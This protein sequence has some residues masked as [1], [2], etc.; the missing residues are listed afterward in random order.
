MARFD[1][2]PPEHLA[3]STV[4]VNSGPMGRAIRDA[5]I[6][7]S[8]LLLPRILP[9]S[10]LE[11]LLADTN[12][13]QAA[14]PIVMRLELTRLVQ[15]KIEAEALRVAGNTAYD[16]AGS[17]LRLLGEM[18]S[19]GV[20][21][22]DLGRVDVEG[23]SDHWARNLAFVAL[24]DRFLS[25]DDALEPEARQRRV[26]DALIRQ[27]ASSP[28]GAPIFIAGSTGSR[29]TT[30]MLIEAVASEEQGH[31]VLPGF[32]FELPQAQWAKLPEDHPQY[33]YASLM[34]SLD[35]TL[36]D[37]TAWA[38]VPSDPNRQKVLS[39]ALRPPPAT[40]HWVKDGPKLPALQSALANVTLI[41]ADTQQQEAQ[42]IALG[43]R[44]AVEEGWSVAVI[45]PDRTLTRRIGAALDRWSIA[46][47]DSAGRPLALSAPGRLL[48]QIS[49]LTW[50][51][52]PLADMLALLKHPLVGTGGDRGQHL[53]FIREFEIWV[54]RKAVAFCDTSV[55]VRWA[56]D[57]PARQAW[58]AWVT[59]AMPAERSD[60]LFDLG[61][62]LGDLERSA[63]A[64]ARGADGTE[65]GGLWEE[66]AGELAWSQLQ[67]LAQAAWASGPVSDADFA[68]ILTSVLQA[69]V[70]DPVLPHDDVVFRG[71]LEARTLDSDLVILAGLNE[72]TWPPTE[73]HDPWLN[74]S[75]RK[76]AGLLTPDRRTGLS[77][78]DFEQ[79][80]SSAHVWFS[81]TLR[82]DDGETV[83]ARWLNRL[84]NLVGGLPTRGGPDALSDIR[85]RGD[86]W[87]SLA[88]EIDRRRPPEAPAPRPAPAPPVSARPKKLSVTA[89]ER[90]V[91]D[92][93]AIYA[94]HILNLQALPQPPDAPDPRLR[95]Q[96]LH[97]V[98]DRFTRQLLEGQLDDAR[99][100]LLDLA[101]E[102][103]ARHV[104]W[105]TTRQLWL[106][107]LDRIADQFVADEAGR[108]ANGSI[109]LREESGDVAFD[110]GAFTLVGR[111]D[112]ID[113]LSDGRFAIYDYKSGKPPTADQIRHFDRQLPLEAL[114]FERGGFGVS[115]KV[116]HIGHIGLGA[117]A[118]ARVHE[119]SSEEGLGLNTDTI[120]GD[121][122][123]L[124]E[125]F[126]SLELGYAA[127]RAI[128]ATHYSGD[129][130]HLARY[131]EWSEA[132]SPS[133]IKVGR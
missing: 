31:V 91:R 126:G 122:R 38:G 63:E 106:A 132:T 125:A 116:R 118:S 120:A 85:T 88:N 128:A 71:T 19:E 29:G 111:A 102:V 7:R 56:K 3:R 121:L 26:V 25:L 14:D 58:A 89:V 54:R 41:E 68:A 60:G 80:A 94:R 53:L 8:P 4:I 83:P 70:R 79:A 39:L 28:P 117:D 23:Y 47:D 33:R 101:K 84:T 87:L 86:H 105:P 20:A 13:P 62:A 2:R 104:P 124:L 22:D 36:P 92:P 127:R 75:L 64:F 32:D 73:D 34:A 115:G 27:W 45:T 93:Y 40:D 77:A 82:T 61:S 129:Y 15:Q 108:Q 123:E 35:L 113:R 95:G 50:P 97:E 12:L 21:S 78:H 42:A 110:E 5:F 51:N 59:D 16:I 109:I 99:A 48:R 52:S 90:L 44:S 119:V 6:A 69:E 130:D 81:R 65:P 98:A 107:R 66:T 37:V 76:R 67:Q 57:D 49:T 55:L 96:V 74:R 72:K 11:T 10:S 18:A 112:R 30:R 1:G 24:V 17:L 133:T 103:F 114:M 43:I 131:G 46:P 100:R 9:L